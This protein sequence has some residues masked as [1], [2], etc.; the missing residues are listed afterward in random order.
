MLVTY[1]FLHFRSVLSEGKTD[2]SGNFFPVSVVMFN[3]YWQV[4]TISLQ[5]ILQNIE[6]IITY[7]KE[8]WNANEDMIARNAAF[9]CTDINREHDS[10]PIVSDVY[11]MDGINGILCKGK[12]SLH[13]LSSSDNW[14]GGVADRKASTLFSSDIMPMNNLACRPRTVSY[15]MSQTEASKKLDWIL[16]EKKASTSLRWSG[17]SFFFAA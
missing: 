6:L 12:D 7:H 3:A 15:S 4:K 8:N 17:R 13:T 1:C 5:N 9:V 14:Y 2:I 11:L 16:A 10:H